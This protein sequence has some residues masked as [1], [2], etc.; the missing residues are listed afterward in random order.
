MLILFRIVQGFHKY[1]RLLQYLQSLLLFNFYQLFDRIS[2][3]CQQN[4]LSKIVVNKNEN[5]LTKLMR[6]KSATVLKFG[7]KHKI[8]RKIL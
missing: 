5:L 8:E 7:I 3:P 2:L 6:K 1:I 4:V